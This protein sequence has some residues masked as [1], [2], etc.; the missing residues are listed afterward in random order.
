[1]CYKKGKERIIQQNVRLFMMC[2]NWGVEIAQEMFDLSY[3]LLETRLERQTSTPMRHN[4][5]S[6]AHRNK[7]TLKLTMPLCVYFTRAIFC[8]FGS[9]DC[10]SN[11]VCGIS[12]S[13]Q[14]TRRIGKML[15]NFL[16]REKY[17]LGEAVQLETHLNKSAKAIDNDRW[18]H[19]SGSYQSEET[20]RTTWNV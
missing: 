2:V 11:N 10:W 19:G 12:T 1:M 20:S 17:R 3:I 13:C 5:K 7:Y 16:F 18:Y 6:P 4:H 8:P 9:S 14:A 15:Y